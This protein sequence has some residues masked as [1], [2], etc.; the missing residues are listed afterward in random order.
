MKLYG[1]S[2][3]FNMD[4]FA[5]TAPAFGYSKKLNRITFKNHEAFWMCVIAAEKSGMM[6]DVPFEYDDDF[7]KH[8]VKQTGIQ[9]P[10]QKDIRKFLQG[11]LLEAMNVNDQIDEGEH[12]KCFQVD[13]KNPDDFSKLVPFAS[14]SLKHKDS[15]TQCKFR[16]I[17][18]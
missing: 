16:D 12:F 5:K 11:Q 10:T 7:L 14:K 17:D 4:D 15:W 3:V 2:P 6:S 8:V 13:G 18:S 9:R 1:S